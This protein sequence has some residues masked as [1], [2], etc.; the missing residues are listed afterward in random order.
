[1]YINKIKCE[2]NGPIKNL[3]IKMPFND[4][5]LPKPL[6]IVGKNGSG[7]SVFLS[8]IVDALYEMAGLNFNNV[9]EADGIGHK[10]YKIISGSQIKIGNSYLYYY[11]DF[12]DNN[13]TF[14]Y[15]FKTGKLLLKDFQNKI[16]VTLNNISDWDE[17]GNYKK[18]NIGSEN[19]K[20]IF[21][22][23][24]ICFFGPDRYEKPDWMGQKYYEHLT[25]K[26]NWA[27]ELK[28]DIT[29]KNVSD[30]NLQ[31]LMD[32]IVDSRIEV[33]LNTDNTLIQNQ[34]MVMNAFRLS[35]ARN[36]LESI[37][38]KILGEDVYFGLNTR[39][40]WSGRFNIKL[41]SNDHVI[42]P[43]L[44]ALSTG[45]IAL[46]N[47]F[48]TII[49]YA[50]NN[51]MNKSIS[52]NNIT[53][54]VIID[55]VEL[56]LHTSL[57]REI[58]PQLIKMFPK[59]Q[60]IITTHAPLFIL[61][62]E[63]VFG[64]ENYEIYQLP[65]VEK[66]TAESFSEFQKAYNYFKDT[67]THNKEIEKAIN[68]NAGTALVI[69]EGSTDWKHMLAAYN[70][71]KALEENDYIF[72][73][74]E[75]KF[76]QYEPKNSKKENGLKLEMGSKQLL[77]MCKSFANLR[78]QRKLIFIADRD[79]KE[80]NDQLGNIANGFKDWG[81]NV[82]SFI[83][84]LPRHRDE[85]PQISI[86]HYYKDEEIRTVV[87]IDG[88]ERRLFMGNEF[89]KYGINAEKNLFCEKR[90][91]CG[92]DKIKIIEGSNGERVLPLNNTEKG[93]NLAL[94]KME[95]A[96]RILQNKKPFDKVDFS[97]FLELFKIIK[98]ILD[99]PLK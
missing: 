26:D 40:Q 72:K 96:S 55:E 9:L 88:V 73:N 10:Y 17:E 2:N 92:S 42:V 38:S 98:T 1:M 20:A 49:R 23:D 30:V 99:L 68:E 15:I 82:Y 83:L 62:M 78:Q 47:M 44:H 27:N 37:M 53:G 14:Q 36:N 94:S 29:V 50:D 87:D 52:L 54:I 7:K 43:N 18:V 39:N 8:N 28:N 35:F 3:N 97:A 5:K 85:T 34:E 56:H 93:P 65:E 64:S 79:E 74:M 16:G 19:S 75:F 91:A 12:N 69:T 31:W 66:I 67:E 6:I 25:I 77:Q 32:L 46:F 45:Q 13:D 48:A 57:Q 33:R 4:Q 81:N 51:D 24:V 63:E 21:E 86:E 11:I 84:P 71:L 60:F 41:K 76:L 80:I 89:D 59:V 95:F 58:L 90:N 61:G 22:K 70:S